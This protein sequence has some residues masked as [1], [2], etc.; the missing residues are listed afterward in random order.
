METLQYLSRSG[1][2]LAILS[3]DSTAG[4]NS[5]VEHN[6]LSPYIQVKMGADGAIDKPD[7]LLFIQACKNLQVEPRST[8][9]VGDSQGDIEMAKRAGA[10]GVVGICW[11]NSQVPYLEAA[12]VT[13]SRLDEI[14]II[15]TV[16]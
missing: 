2:K 7:P 5:F 16:T 11:G 15:T 12:D 6:Q 4:V 1:L 8:I 9:M 13:I 10:A 3:A 14:K